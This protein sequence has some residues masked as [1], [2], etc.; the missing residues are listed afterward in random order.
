MDEG[1]VD[2]DIE[3]RFTYYPPK[4][5]E[6]RKLFVTLREKAKELA[7]LYAWAVPDSREKSLALT[8]LEESNMWANA[9]IARH[10]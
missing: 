1:Q 10:E 2:Q 7:N 3:N 9:A 8:K 6:Q 5:D 4:S